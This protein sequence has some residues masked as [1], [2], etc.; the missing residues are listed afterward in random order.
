MIIMCMFCYLF[1]LA[2]ANLTQ[3]IR[4]RLLISFKI[5]ENGVYQK[6]STLPGSDLRSSPSHQANFE[7]MIG[8]L[9]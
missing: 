5:Y 2:L 4:T 3:S 7:S 1:L 9:Y 8:S 6:S